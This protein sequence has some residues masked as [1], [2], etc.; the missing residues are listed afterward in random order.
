M[1]TTITSDVRPRATHAKP[2][3]KGKLPPKVKEQRAVAYQASHTEWDA[4]TPSSKQEIERMVELLKAVK[5]GD[6]SVRLPYK[7]DGILSRAG[8]ILNDIIG[9]NEHLANEVVRVGKVVGQEGRMTERGSVGPA[10][11]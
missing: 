7:K 3:L 9:L 11:G 4:L 10:K 1:D 8:E 5:E 2:K 6:F